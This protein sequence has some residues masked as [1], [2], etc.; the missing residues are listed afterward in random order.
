MHQNTN[1]ELERIRLNN[2]YQQMNYKTSYTANEDDAPTYWSYLKLRIGFSVLLLFFITASVKAFD[3]S[4]TKK[5]QNVIKQMDQQD[6]Y[7]QK[8][9]QQI[10]TSFTEK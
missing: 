1:L 2:K 10:Q 9:L 3:S 6:P 4:E 7:T 5:V 8:I